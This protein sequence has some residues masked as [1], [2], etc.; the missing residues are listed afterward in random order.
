M[1]KFSNTNTDQSMSAMMT[2]ERQKL[3]SCL[4][5]FV[6]NMVIKSKDYNNE[7]MNLVVHG[8]FLNIRYY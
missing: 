8:F 1:L 5:L 4:S 3:S 2:A 7:S 6:S